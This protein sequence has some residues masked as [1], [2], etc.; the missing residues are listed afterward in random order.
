MTPLSD[1]ELGGFEEKPGR[2]IL[3]YL[4][5]PLRYP[6]ALL[7][8]FI[9]V[10]G[11]AVLIAMVAPRKYR[12]GTLILVESK[13]LSE[14]MV[15]PVSAEGMAQRIST[16]RQVV[17][18]R[19][20]LETVIKKTDAYPELKDQPA[21]VVVEAMRRS[22][23]IRVQGADAF[24]IEYVNKDPEKAMAVTNLLASQ[25]TEDAE[26]LQADLANKAFA[27]LQSNLGEARN[28]VEQ[29]EA[30]LRKHKQKYWGA[31]PEQL[32][33]NLRVL[34]QLQVEQQTLGEN[35]RTL[36]DR[37]ATLER[38]LLEG[39]RLATSTGGTTDSDLAQLR[40]VY[41]T[42][43]GR[44]TDDHPD[45][46]AVRA[47]IERLEK[48]AAASP[49]PK[50]PLNS[51]DH[52][53]ASLSQSLQLVEREIDGFKAR[54]EK[55]DQR[56]VEFQ[57]RI[58]ATPKAEQELLALTRDYQQL[59]ENYNAALR[60]ENDAQM[61]QRLDEYWKGGYF[62]VL[63]PAYLPRRP[64]RPYGLLILLGGLVVGVLC[65]LFGAVAADLADRTVKSERDLDG[66]AGPLLVTL[67]RLRPAA[68]RKSWGRR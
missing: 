22:I 58:E 28:S 41:R 32:D 13:S 50:D 64:I 10:V 66:L 24:V 45:V 8:P 15:P 20:R 43:R 1:L 53:A 17:T 42:L 14:G 26:H 19:T 5:I 38:S 60:K 51:A 4:E 59:R 6:K 37:R 46:Q 57:A 65:G 52:E 12:S 39:R 30:A 61:A 21:H 16:I 55:L 7:A 62:R 67:P 29:R 31:L 54:R 68:R 25:F 48:Q 56:I 27:F 9:L 18:S 40:A 34:Q 3:E 63:D 36:E 35:L 2:D 23:E 47:R 11:I 49:A 33:S 44:Y